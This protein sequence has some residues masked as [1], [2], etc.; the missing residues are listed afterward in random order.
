M[1]V[2]DQDRRIAYSIVK[3]LRSQAEA[4]LG[5]DGKEEVEGNWMT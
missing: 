4:V 2:G 5:E 1:S 3:H